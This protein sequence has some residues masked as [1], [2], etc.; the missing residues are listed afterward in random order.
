M[1][2]FGESASCFF[3]RTATAVDFKRPDILTRFLTESGKLIGRSESKLCGDHQ[4]Q[5]SKAVKRA[6]ELGLVPG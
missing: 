4:L 6:R 2:E 5:V 1:N 3:C